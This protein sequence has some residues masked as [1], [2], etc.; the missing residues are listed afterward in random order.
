MGL[1]NCKRCGTLFLM[2][3]SEYCPECAKWFADTYS[4]I[5]D[6][7]RVNPGKTLWDVHTDL[8]MSLSVVQQVIR[9]TE[10]QEKR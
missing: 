8:N 1:Q 10:E 4:R 2:Q 5:R 9:F 3:K 7:L 6:Y